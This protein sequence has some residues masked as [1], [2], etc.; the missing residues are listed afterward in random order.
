MTRRRDGVP[1][2]YGRKKN[3]KRAGSRHRWSTNGICRFCGRF[4]EDVYRIR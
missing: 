3:G 1:G 4:K 2:C